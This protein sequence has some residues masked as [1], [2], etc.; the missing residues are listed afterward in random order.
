M[1]QWWSCCIRQSGESWRGV[2]IC[3]KG[4]GWWIE[5]IGTDVGRSYEDNDDIEI[6]KEVMSKDLAEEI[7]IGTIVEK[8]KSCSI[9][10]T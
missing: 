9:N 3:G 1:R 2:G 7:D 4:V 10:L 5:G 8:G 6:G